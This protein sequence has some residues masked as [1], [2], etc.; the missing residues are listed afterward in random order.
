V[1]AGAVAAALALAATVAAPAARAEPPLWPGRGAGLDGVVLGG[2]ALGA[3]LFELYPVERDHRWHHELFGDLDRRTE[4]HVS[5]GAAQLSNGTLVVTVLVPPTLL[6]RDGLD[7]DAGRRVLVL[8]EALGVDLLIAGAVKHVVQRP[9]P[10]VYDRDPAV[11]AWAA[12][13][14]ADSRLSFYSGHAAVAFGA[15]VAGSYLYGAHSTDPDARALIWGFEL[16]SATVTAGLRIRA[17]RHF[18]SDVVV[19]AVVGSGVGWA[20]AALRGPD[21]AYTPSGREVAAMAG[22]VVGGAVLARLLPVD[23]DGAAPGDRA[24]AVHARLAPLALA[25]GGGLAAVGTF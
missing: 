8:G 10:Y 19:G 5:S 14:G 17:G 1:R 6:V 15:A 22:G 3:A 9:R 16:M 4:G 12:R 25:G 24:G 18:P 21:G 13:Q 23:D 20:V 7:D 11:V 2:A